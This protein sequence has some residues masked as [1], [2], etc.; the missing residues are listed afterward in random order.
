MR[1]GITPRRCSANSPGEAILATVQRCAAWLLCDAVQHGRALERGRRSPRRGTDVYSMLTQDYAVMSG[2]RDWSPP[3]L[4]I[5]C[6]QPR[7]PNTI[8]G[9]A[10]PSPTLWGYVATRRR[11][12]SYCAP[13]GLPSA[14]PS[15]Q[16]TDDESMETPTP[17]PLK[18]L[19][20]GHRAR[21][22]ASTEA[23]FART[24]V[25]CVVLCTIPP[26]VA[27]TV[28]HTCKLPPPWPIKGGAVPWPQGD[29]RGHSPHAFCL[30]HYIGTYL[31]QYLS[32]LE[33]RPPLPP[34]L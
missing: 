12:A 29:E 6:G 8:L 3:S 20:G 14:T 10:L 5:L 7:R 30:H 19:L 25:H 32:D 13:Y 16:C 24:T 31:N 1:L 26:H 2:Q 15:R 21:H 27:R 11:H 18:P 4:S 17:P 28:W 23:R 33:A 34:R 9:T 22:D